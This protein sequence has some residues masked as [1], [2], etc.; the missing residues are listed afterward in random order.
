MRPRIRTKRVDYFFVVLV[1]LLVAFGLAML[2][3][4]SSFL[5]KIKFNDTYFYLKHQI[6]HGLLIGLLGFFVTVNVYYRRWEK[7]ALIFLAVGLLLL[8]LVFSS[9]GFVSGGAQRWLVIGPISFQPSEIIKLTFLIY[10]AAWLSKNKERNQ[11]FFRGFLPFVFLVTLIAG[12]LIAQHSTSATLIFLITTILVYFISGAK[13][14]YI[15]LIIFLGLLFMPLLIYLAPYRWERIMTFL[16][17]QIDP[18]GKSY[19]IN[20][21]ILAIGSG[22]L[23]GRGYGQSIAKIHYLPEQIGDSIFA[24]I[25]EELGF[26]GVASLIV[27]FFLLLWRSFIIS[28]RTSDN[29]AKLLIIGFS[30]TIGLQVFVHIA[31]LTGVIPLTGVPLPFI[32]YG[33]TSLAVF[34][35][36]MGIIANISKYA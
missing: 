11:N 35:T 2:S 25:A 6:I 10:L 29:F 27:A 28:A 23:W 36:M 1:F 32:S 31:A 5:G 17:P 24:V 34:L 9:L 12:I 18:L 33:G 15:F 21:T 26:V 13:F 8:V 4:S 22:K 3:S 20:Q 30:L 16:N 7:L 14:R 19:Q